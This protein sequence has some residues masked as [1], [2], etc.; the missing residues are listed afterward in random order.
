MKNFFSRIMRRLRGT[1]RA[2]QGAKMQTWAIGIYSGDSPYSVGPSDG[3]NNPVL[4]GASVSDVPALYVADPFMIKTAGTWHMFF[5]VLNSQSGRGEIGLASSED[6]RRWHYQWIVLR[7]SFHLSYPY[8]FEWKN[9]YYMVPESYQAN[10]VRIYRAIDFPLK[11][12]FVGDLLVGDVFEDS[13]LFRFRDYWWLL[14]DLAKPPYW[15][16]TLRLFFA[17]H[18]LGPWSEHPS[19]P[20]VDGNP[21][22]ARPAGR[23]V[24]LDDRVIRFTQDCCPVYGTQVRAFEI[25]DLTVTT[26]K[27][28]SLNIPPVLQSSGEGWNECGMHHID[29]HLG[30]DGKWIACVDGWYWK[31]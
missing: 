2:S 18:L 4:T 26:F 20:I 25:T 19:S 23:V 15:A 28:R 1:S 6:T 12:A 3:I 21:H 11:W 8:V 9:E 5:E 10:S 29:P 30:D 13:S 24:V 17:S 16:G 27:E 31:S 14:T 22:I 7:E